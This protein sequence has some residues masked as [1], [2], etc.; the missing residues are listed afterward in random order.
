MTS[1]TTQKNKR[2]L[3]SWAVSLAILMIGILMVTYGWTLDHLGHSSWWW[4][5]ERTV[6]RFW[7]NVGDVATVGGGLA[8][9]VWVVKTALVNSKEGRLP[10]INFLPGL[11]QFLRRQHVLFGW[12]GFALAIAHS[13]Y[14]LFIQPDLR[15]LHFYT[16]LFAILSMLFVVGFGLFVQFRQK[17]RGKMRKWHFIAASVFAAGLLVHIL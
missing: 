2:T 14:F 11:F 12:G 6:K 10:K 13:V 1:T 16:G 5:N 8:F 7:Y 4:Q 17:D 9:A 3:P 15:S